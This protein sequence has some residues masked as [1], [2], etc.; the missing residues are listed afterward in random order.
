MKNLQKGFTLIELMI[1]VA[2]IGIL[3]AVAIPSYQNYTLKAKF[4][5]VVSAAGGLKTGIEV[6]AA[7]GNCG[8]NGTV[9]GVTAGSNDVPALPA[10]SGMLGSISVNGAGVITATAVTTNGL[11]GETYIL[12]PAMSS[13]DGKITWTVSGSCKTRT[14][15]PLC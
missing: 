5:D 11:N 7:A 2:I 14:A 3:A 6:C 9:S 4:T 12:T 15:G 13:T 8:S 1:V 10:A